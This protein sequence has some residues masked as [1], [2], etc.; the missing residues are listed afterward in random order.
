MSW[1]LI[2]ANAQGAVLYVFVQQPQES[3]HDMY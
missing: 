2:A 3:D 1:T